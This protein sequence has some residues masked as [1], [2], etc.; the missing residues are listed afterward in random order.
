MSRLR[1]ERKKRTREEREKK[2]E[3]TNQTIKSLTFRPKPGKQHLPAVAL[4]L[5][6]SQR[7]VCFPEGKVL[8][9][10]WRRE[11]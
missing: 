11:N 3:K 4:D 5:W 6:R 2:G 9:T 7:V 1:K 10:W 8:G